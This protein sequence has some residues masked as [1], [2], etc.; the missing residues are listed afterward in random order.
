MELTRRHFGHGVGAS[1][2]AY[3]LLDTLWATDAW[4]A[5]LRD[6]AAAWLAQVNELS[7][8]TKLGQLTQQQWQS[9]VE[10]L[11][12]E[13]ELP[14][15]L[16]LLDFEKLTANIKYREKG[17]RSLR[18]RLPEV[19]GLPRLLVFGHQVFALK[20]GRSVPPH[21]HNNMATL[22]LILKGKLHGKHFDRLEDAQDHFVIRPTIDRSFGPGEYSTITD[23]KDNVP[24]VQGDDRDGLHLQYPCPASRPS[25]KSR[26]ASLSRPARKE[27][28]RRPH[29]RAANA[30]RGVYSQV[31]LSTWRRT[32][33]IRPCRLTRQ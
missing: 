19:E 21:G 2:L 8:S 22:F 15:M 24:L 11:L 20:K 18:P 14:E 32:T 17:E 16:Q 29:S 13:V 5:P 9:K 27:T 25:Q 4:G 23:F 6:K 12:S 7:K 28:G 33:R 31:R 3:S 30:T 10:E 1:L 26:R